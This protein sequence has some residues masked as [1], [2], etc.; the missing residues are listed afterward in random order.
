M[1][2][3]DSQY[4]TVYERLVLRDDDLV[5]LIAYALYK[6]RKRAWVV[7]FQIPEKPGSEP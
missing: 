6:Q 3:P 5:G 7:D 4:N 1:S 2:D